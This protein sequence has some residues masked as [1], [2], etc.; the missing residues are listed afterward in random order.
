MPRSG[1]GFR[2]CRASAAISRVWGG[3]RF[4]VSAQRYCLP[5]PFGAPISGGQNPG[6]NSMRASKVIGLQA[7]PYNYALERRIDDGPGRQSIRGRF[8]RSVNRLGFMVHPFPGD[9]LYPLLEEFAG[10]R[11]PSLNCFTVEPWL[12]DQSHK[13]GSGGL[14]RQLSPLP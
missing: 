14:R 4:P 13:R 2:C 7:R 6:P 11:P 3:V 1:I 10:L 12:R 5:V 8:S 9:G